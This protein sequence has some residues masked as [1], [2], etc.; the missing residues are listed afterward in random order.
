MTRFRA[1]ARLPA[2]SP[3]RICSWVPPSGPTIRSPIVSRLKR[4]QRHCWPAGLRGTHVGEAKRLEKH[5]PLQCLRPI[6]S[7]SNGGELWVPVLRHRP[8][9]TAVT[10]LG[11]AATVIKNMHLARY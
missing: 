5:F 2:L 8:Q 7:P 10:S 3:V 4:P 1:P 11:P 6:K 9:T